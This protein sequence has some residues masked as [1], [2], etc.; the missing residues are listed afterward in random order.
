M[1][2]LRNYTVLDAQKI[3]DL[4]VLAF[5][6]FK[7]FYDN[8]QT[9]SEKLAS[10][11]ELSH[12]AEIIVAEDLNGEILG[13]V[14][15][16][17]EETIKAEYFPKNTPIIRMLV[18]NPTVRGLGIGKA[19]SLECICRAKRDNCQNIAL[20]TSSIMSIALPMYLRMNF[21]EYGKAPDIYSVKYNVYLK[22]ID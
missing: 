16:V 18:V 1:Y 19:L 11:S 17:P 5:D 3:N 12:T 15:Y 22:S 6:Q 10:F 13:A 21:K 9:F 2:K 7:T 14:A 20:H 4:A 8:W